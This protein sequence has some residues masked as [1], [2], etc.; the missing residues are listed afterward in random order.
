M[1]VINIKQGYLCWDQLESIKFQMNA[2][3]NFFPLIKVKALFNN[4]LGGC[5]IHSL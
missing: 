1:D 4:I 3:A 2:H 5:Y